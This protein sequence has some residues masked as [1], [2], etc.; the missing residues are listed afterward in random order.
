QGLALMAQHGASASRGN[1]DDHASRSATPP[2]HDDNSPLHSSNGSDEDDPRCP[3]TRDI[4]RAPI[5]TGFERPPPLGA[6]DGQTDPDEHIDN[7]NAI[8]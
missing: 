6:Y 2:R 4:M 8:L 7:I 5:P 3:L 1:R